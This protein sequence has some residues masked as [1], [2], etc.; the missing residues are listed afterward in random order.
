MKQL[1]TNVG[2]FLVS[3]VL[4]NE[5]A[6]IFD[7][8]LSPFTGPV[9]EAYETMVFRVKDGEIDYSDLD[10]DRYNSE[11]EATKGHQAMIDKW[12]NIT[13]RHQ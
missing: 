11:E 8:I 6:R 12:K 5:T 1:K 3:T 9:P 10:M 2:E 4:L 13:S 7:Q